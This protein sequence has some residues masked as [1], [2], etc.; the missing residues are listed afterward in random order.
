MSNITSIRARVIPQYP[1]FIT[2]T[3][4]IKVERESN[5]PDLVVRPAYEQLG[6]IATVPDAAVNYF[7]MWN[8][9][10]GVYTRIPFQGM[11]DVA[12]VAFGFPTKDAA[13]NA[14]IT[15]NVHAIEVYGDATVG[16]GLG[17]LYID[18]NNGASDTFVSGDGRTWYLA[19]DVR[20]PR[21]TAD[22]GAKIT[23]TEQAA[24]FTDIAS[25]QAA[26]VPA[27][28][29]RL[30]TQFFSVGTQTGAANYKRVP[31]EPSHS[32]KFRS[33]DR[34]LPDGTVSSGNGGW[35]E[36]NE[37]EITPEMCGAKGDL[38]ADDAA[39]LTIWGTLTG[40]IKATGSYRMAAPLTVAASRIAAFGSIF[41]YDGV[42]EGRVVT[43][44][45]AGA[46]W[47]GGEIDG[48]LKA[49]RGIH[50]AAAG[51]IVENTE[52][53]GL[54][55]TTMNAV[56]I[57]FDGTGGGT[58]RRNKIYDVAAA[59]NG[60][61]GDGNGPS[62]AIQGAAT[63]ALSAPFIF[64]DNEAYDIAGEEG[65]AIQILVFDGS[66]P[67]SSAAWSIVR[68]NHV[69][70]FNRRGIKVQ[71]SKV[72]VEDNI[73]FAP[74]VAVGGGPQ[75]I[76]S[77]IAGNDIIIR[78]N[79]VEA[80]S[81]MRGIY[82]TQSTAPAKLTGVMITDNILNGVSD[83][84]GYVVTGLSQAVVSGNIYGT[85]RRA[86]L[87]TDCENSLI[88]DNVAANSVTDG[89]FTDFE[90]GSTNTRMLVSN[91]TSLGGTKYG[92]MGAGAPLS[93]YRASTSLRTAGAVVVAAATA[94]DSL[95]ADSSGMT[96]G[97]GVVVAL[98]SEAATAATRSFQLGTVGG[99]FAQD[100]LFTS[101]IPSTTRSA[102]YHSRGTIAFNSGTGTE[103]GWRC[104][105]SGTPGTWVAFS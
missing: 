51:C 33:Q 23:T 76:I 15:S 91:N 5:G 19:A 82:V 18:V 16:D 97:S 103:A 24:T 81:G 44:T 54:R 22:L 45:G 58:A 102:R 46:R 26:T 35:W 83:Q 32:L 55:A 59:G 77:A 93:V 90:V 9:E 49:S 17:G 101:A 13:Q 25:A 86:V 65:D 53:H 40:R 69:R 29:K 72:I 100:I 75:E 11:F 21:L 14:I 6:D 31:S 66:L 12:G 62:R 98:S 68:R 10:T 88:A 1:S 50:T 104:S 3:D 61:P 41:K 48:N 78:R 4:G 67:Y 57:Y 7:M 74:T 36:I 95:V 73:C 37:L 20:E 30:R 71:A 94:V 85:G 89:T 79:I 92:S 99:Q 70:G 43:L 87:A 8:A 2:G 38:V 60:T 64:E 39:A 56:G 52:I 42:A 84:D 27:R 63:A 34:Y 28:N 47:N 80:V 96:T 105:V